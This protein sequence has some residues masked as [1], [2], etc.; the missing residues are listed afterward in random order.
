[1]NIG[2]VKKYRQLARQAE[3]SKLQDLEVLR[4]RLLA[5]KGKLARQRIAIEQEKDGLAR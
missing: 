2:R 4:Q 1:M 5:K 3:R